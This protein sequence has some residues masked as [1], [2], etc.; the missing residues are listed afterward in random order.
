MK[1]IYFMGG[2]PRSGSM[3][4]STLLNQ[5][6]KIHVTTTTHTPNLILS[7]MNQKNKTFPD[8]FYYALMTKYKNVDFE[9]I[10]DKCRDWNTLFP[11]ICSFESNPKMIV[12]IR[13]VKEIVASAI[14]L[15]EKNPQTPFYQHHKSCDKMEIAMSFYNSY[16]KN[17]IESL[18]YTMDNYSDQLCVVHY[19]DLI[20]NPS[21]VLTQVYSFCGFPHNE[22][23]YFTGLKVREKENDTMWGIKGLHD[24]APNINP[25]I[26]RPEEYL[27]AEVCYMLDNMDTLHQN[28]GIIV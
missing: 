17:L 5:N 10:V 1:L 28:Q 19:H 6:S 3:L 2:L 4:L 23:H 27:G 11:Q 13:P 20:T 21:K 14:R 18:K 16:I 7:A 15:F 22:K 26:Y 24:V 12:T 9:Y 8:A 25:K